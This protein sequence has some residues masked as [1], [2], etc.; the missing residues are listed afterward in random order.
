MLWIVNKFQRILGL[1][2][3]ENIKEYTKVPELLKPIV[4]LHVDQNTSKGIE[5]QILG[6]CMVERPGWIRM[7]IHP[8]ITTQ[9][10]LY[11]C[12]SIKQV[13]ENYK[14]WGADYEY[15][16]AKNN[17]AKP[18]EALLVHSWFGN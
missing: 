7:S 16:A 3:S 15:N 17:K 6:G 11:V 8:T 18:I 4:L 2:V 1:K 12:E 9:E 14:E 10:V 5:K 13:A